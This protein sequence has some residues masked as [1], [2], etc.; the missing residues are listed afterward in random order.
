LLQSAP[1]LKVLV[2]SREPLHLYGESEF[3]VSPLEI[4]NLDELPA[5]EELQ[6]YPSVALFIDRAR[7]VNPDFVLSGANARAIAE[8]CVRLDGLPLAIELAAARIKLLS[9]NAMLGRLGIRFSWLTS[10]VSHS[11][12]RHQTLRKAIDWSYDL[13]EEGELRL[14]ERLSVFAGCT[15]EAVEAVC[16]ADAKLSLIVFEQLA[17]L[18]DK[19]LIVREE[20]GNGEP[21]FRML[22]TIREYAREKLEASGEAKT[23]QQRHFT[24]FVKLAEMA[25]AQRRGPE[26]GLWLQRFEIEHDN[27]RAALNYGL[28]REEAEATLRL[29]ATLEWFWSLRGYLSEGSKWMDRVLTE[30]QNV[31]ASVRTK[32]LQAAEHLAQKRGDFLQ[33]KRYA[34]EHFD[35]SRSVDD[36]AGIAWAYHSLGDVARDLEGDYEQ[37]ATLLDESVAIF[38]E[39]GE[40]RGMAGALNCLGEVARCQEKYQQAKRFYEESLSLERQLDDKERV[41]LVSFNLGSV[42]L[43]QG[44]L[45]DAD[46]RFKTSMALSQELGNK[47]IIALC[48]SGLAGIRRERGNPRQAARLLAAASFIN[49]TIGARLDKA[50]RTEWDR[51]LASIHADLD[52]MSFAKAWAR[53]EKMTMEQAISYAYEVSVNG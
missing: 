17:S 36:S 13:L 21:Y 50:D 3:P 37:A 46:S 16:D 30:C 4:P 24:Y 9:P 11:P 27:L 18:V 28:E 22:E 1:G 25:E 51:I 53:G 41:A 12:A 15:I 49:E 26:E 48:L 34:Q 52:P 42:E 10:G 2:T 20:T 44:A 43:Y 23:I 35:L 31:S 7:A 33:K 8:L 6:H 38:R 5:L 47:S 14:F 45:D 29:A 19:N 40:K 39:L 32:T